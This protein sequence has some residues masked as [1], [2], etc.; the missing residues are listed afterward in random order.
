MANPVW[1][2]KGFEITARS[3][4]SPPLK[5]GDVVNKALLCLLL[6]IISTVFMWTR[7]YAGKGILLPTI[8]AM[9]G[10]LAGFYVSFRVPEISVVTVPLF[11][12]LEGLTVGGVSALV[13]F[14]YPGVV[15]NAVTLTYLAALL[16]LFMYRFEF[17]TQGNRLFR[18]FS[19]ATGSILL[20]YI[21]KFLLGIFSINVL[22]FIS[23]IGMLLCLAVVIVGSINLTS[24]MEFIKER[25]DIGIRKRAEWTAVLGVMVTVGWVYLEV[26][27][28]LNMVKRFVSGQIEE[29]KQVFTSKRDDSS[30]T[31]EVKIANKIE[32][33]RNKK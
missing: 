15:L 2:N 16:I 5:I 28:L 6:L 20:F 9:G 11:M 8:I 31:D 13:E 33:D 7:F 29:K 19:L 32:P 3:T 26:A 18:T 30:N 24:D 21:L 25:E 12:I 14:F 27:R 22:G 23:P 10:G 4:G 1:K 17:L